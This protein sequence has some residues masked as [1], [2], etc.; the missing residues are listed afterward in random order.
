MSTW[1]AQRL[2]VHAG[3]S[4]RPA[5]LEDGDFVLP[6]Y[7]VREHDTRVRRYLTEAVDRGQSLLVVVRGESCTGKTR[8]MFEAVQATVPDFDLFFPSGPDTLR[9]ALEEGV[10]GTRT[11]LWLNEA[12][13]YLSGTQGDATAEAL[14]RRLDDDT[15]LIAIATL[16]PHQ[17]DKLT[18]RPAT[19]GSAPHRSV[20]LLLH[21]AR[22]VN[23]PCSFAEHLEAVRAHA[24]HDSSLAA[25]LESGTPEI[26]QVLAAGPD[27]VDRYENPSDINGVYAQAV[28]TAAM[29]L[30][31]LIAVSKVPLKF[32][33]AA[34]PDYLTDA[35]RA[36]ADPGT[37]FNSALD[38]A[39]VLVK[40]V[41]APLERVPQPTGMGRLPGVVRL[42]DYLQQHG[43]IRRSIVFPPRSFWEAAH[44]HLTEPDDLTALGGA[45]SSRARYQ[46][47]SRLFEQAEHRGGRAAWLGLTWLWQEAGQ[48][49]QAEWEAQ[50][51]AEAGKPGALRWLARQRA[52]A[53][54]HQ[55]AQCLNQQAAEA[56]DADALEELA[57]QRWPG[58]I[59]AAEELALRAAEAGASMG[60]VLLGRIHEKTG[61][62]PEAIEWY[63]RAVQVNDAE[64]DALASLVPLLEEA[65][66]HEGAQEAALQA[67]T[68]LGSPECLEPLVEWRE[69]TGNHQ[70]AE[71]AAQFEAEAGAPRAL[72]LLAR[73]REQRGRQADAERLARRA[74]DADG[75]EALLWLAQRR[76]NSGD[77]DAADQLY[78]YALDAASAQSLLFRAYEYKRNGDREEAER[79]CRVLAAGQ[80]AAI[81]LLAELREQVG[82]YRQAEQL[83]QRAADAQFPE[84]MAWLAQR[85]EEA[86]DRDEA[87][88]AVL[89]ALGVD[90]NDES[91]TDRLKWLVERRE[92]S[93]DREGAE[94]LAKRGLDAGADDA[95]RWLAE[96][97]QESGDLQGA[98][99]LYEYAAQD[100]HSFGQYG[101]AS[102]L[103]K[104]GNRQAAQSAHLQC[105]NAGYWLADRRMAAFLGGEEGQRMMRYGLELDG[106]PCAPWHRGERD[107]PSVTALPLA[108]NEGRKGY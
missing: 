96:Q 30:H 45:A 43:H 102:C 104:E 20:M 61:N 9:A 100:G 48:R 99:L 15:P 72:E 23:V 107:W 68:V 83:Y 10:L 14:L 51:A 37:W 29:D 76:R 81:A 57:W 91:V 26:T 21:Q 106:S 4:G 50:Q 65:G 56:G 62:R 5:H 88:Q 59:A 53:G 11:V 63:R 47:A 7:V 93:G 58:D 78:Q 60:M 92:E 94:Q 3:V 2:G 33:R 108:G 67:D 90:E 18:A 27:L 38:S 39:S 95:L 89:A 98:Q 13:E 52:L 6:T 46:V 97:R 71:A 55:T 36:A 69:D 31:R 103:A 19:D 44:D 64:T 74:A 73:L 70:R 8:T 86:G 35:Q 80:P 54:D 1:T 79:L 40:N 41:A 75:P 87:E 16:H 105:V 28:I 22:R 101:L 24:A 32:L 49:E 12:H 34:A 82:D 85:L 25:A 84:A 17:Y 66:D 77:A 42:A